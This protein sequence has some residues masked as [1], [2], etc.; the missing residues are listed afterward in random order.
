MVNALLTP[1]VNASG[2]DV[3]VALDNTGIDVIATVAL[4]PVR[5][6]QLL[7]RCVRKGSLRE[8]SDYSA[9]TPPTL[10]HFGIRAPSIP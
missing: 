5:H 1:D 10:Y 9:V 8:A 2:L 7:L 6:P 3:L 4:V